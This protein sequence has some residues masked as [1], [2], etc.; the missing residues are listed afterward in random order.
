MNVPFTIGLRSSMVMNVFTVGLTR[1][2]SMEMYINKLGLCQREV[3]YVKIL[4]LMMQRLMVDALADQLERKR[5]MVVVHINE[6]D[7]DLIARWWRMGT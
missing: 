1:L 5:T 2:L 4:G 3:G 7:Q 6:H